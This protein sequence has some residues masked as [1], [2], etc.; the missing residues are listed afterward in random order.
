MISIIVCSVNPALRAFLSENI[1]QTIGIADFELIIIENEVEKHSIT[2]A[3]N[4]GAA[5]AKY[6]YLC[7]CHEDVRFLS[8]NWGE[9]ITT[10]LSDQETGLIGVAGSIIKPAAPSGIWLNNPH[11]DRYFM[12]QGNSTGSDY[13]KYCNPIGEKK[14][15][16]KVVDGLFMGCRRAIWEENK[17]DE[18]VFTGFHGYDLDF[19]LQ[20][21]RKYKLYVIYDIELVH[22]SNGGNTITWLGNMLKVTEKWKSVLPVY[23]PK[24]EVNMLNLAEYKAYDYFLRSMIDNRYRLFLAFN[25]TIKLFALQP[26]NLNNLRVIKYFLKNGKR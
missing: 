24:F 4:I 16:V 20:I 26:L 9:K 23:T 25:L 3:Y 13:I 2:K 15:E 5:K 10:H 19:S 12:I 7:F 17:F 22:L 11:T 8:H 14:S 18:V 1:K 21:Q 6:P